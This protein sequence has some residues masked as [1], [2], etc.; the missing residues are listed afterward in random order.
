MMSY[1]SKVAL[2]SGA[3]DYAGM[4]P[5]A[6]LD[7]Q[8]TLKKAATFRKTGKHPWLMNRVVLAL[9]EF[10]KIS[11]R[12]LFE[13]GAD[14]TP[15]LFSI[16]ANPVTGNSTADFEKSVDWDFRELRRFQEKNY[17]SSCRQ[18]VVSYEIR[19]PDEITAPGQGIT[20]GE[21]IFPALEK[22][23]TIWPGEMDVY[24]E[25]SLEGDWED[26]LEGVTRIMAEWLSENAESP[27]VPALKIRTGGKFVPRPEQLAKAIDECASLGVKFKAT[28]GL[29]KPLSHGDQFGFI[30][31]FAAIN[32][33]FSLGSESFSLKDIEACLRDPNPKNFLFTEA[34]FSWNGKSISNEQIE[35][36]RKQHA[37]TF[38]SCSLDEPDEF[39]L[40]EFP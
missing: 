35:S 17:Y 22:I 20:S 36:A 12:L 10:K 33:A 6:S 37:A 34:D 16:L 13:C 5:P 38:G 39:L 14:G 8:S 7:L 4:F 19:L 2:L 15:W 23:E 21:Y 28:Q 27:L 31:L 1:Q 30:N 32:L 9:G 29:H 25:A 3:I 26:T 40:K 18:E 11:P 24:F